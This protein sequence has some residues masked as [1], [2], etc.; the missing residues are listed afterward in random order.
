MMEHTIHTLTMA[1]INEE[2]NY[3]AIHGVWQEDTW[4]ALTLF[5]QRT[6]DEDTANWLIVDGGYIDVA[7]LYDEV[8]EQ[9]AHL[10]ACEDEM[11]DEQYKNQH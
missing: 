1:F 9:L 2:I 3:H 10:V 4:G 8:Y 6:V 11:D 7:E 5:L